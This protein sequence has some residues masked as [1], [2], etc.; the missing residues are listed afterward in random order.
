[1]HVGRRGARGL[2]EEGVE[3]LGLGRREVHVASA[4]INAGLASS[5]RAAWWCDQ[6]ARSAASLEVGGWS[7]GSGE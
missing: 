2:D 3:L 6:K 7:S 5:G 4:G 1:M